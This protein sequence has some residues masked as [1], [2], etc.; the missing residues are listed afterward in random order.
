MVTM[1]DE[2]LIVGQWGIS[3]N[4]LN[5]YGTLTFRDGKVSLV[6]TKRI[7]IANTDS[8]SLLGIG[9]VKS[10]SNDK[11]NP[12]MITLK[13]VIETS[14]S[15]GLKFFPKNKVLQ[16]HHYEYIA[17]TMFIGNMFI[18]DRSKFETVKAYPTNFSQWLHNSMKDFE[19]SKLI[20]NKLVISSEGNLANSILS[21][22]DRDTYSFKRTMLSRED[23]QID[24]L[25][26]TIQ[27]IDYFQWDR[28][29]II[30]LKEAIALLSKVTSWYRLVTN[31]NE[32][33]FKASFADGNKTVDF[34]DL[35]KSVIN[36]THDYSRETTYFRRTR[37]WKENVLL[38]LK[39]WIEDYD[40]L[41]P[42]VVGIYPPETLP[43]EFKLETVCAE[44]ETIVNNY[45]KKMEK[46]YYKKKVSYFVDQ[47]DDFVTSKIF[48][49]LSTNVDSE[50]LADMIKKYRNPLSHNFIEAGQKPLE[51]KVE[52]FS[53]IKVMIRNWLLNEI[54]VDKNIIKEEFHIF[55][56]VS[57]G[58]VKVFSKK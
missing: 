42:L 31:K 13:G 4:Q 18:N 53:I 17:L 51:E 57:Q 47:I 56:P 39:K 30:S 36:E 19:Q 40:R 58:M 34:F 55:N 10:K 54:G 32:S 27:V 26:R 28:R 29:G 44:I 6:T 33:V 49:L 3:E 37:E 41:G 7:E 38:S 12:F 45:Y 15:G 52:L 23:N 43:I 2:F 8:P 14:R 25:D 48:G 20:K 16:D 1:L 9:H 46:S 35:T 21:N 24:R 11:D 50:S 22:K 5:S